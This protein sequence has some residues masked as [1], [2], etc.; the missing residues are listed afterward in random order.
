M[1]GSGNKNGR[2]EPDVGKG[3]NS[4][5]LKKETGS[6][7]FPHVSFFMHG[8]TVDGFLFVKSVILIKNNY[9]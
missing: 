7:R 1:A 5:C 8:K 6:I 2:R 9:F 3:R 4:N